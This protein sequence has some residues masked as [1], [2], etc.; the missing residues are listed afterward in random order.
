MAAGASFKKNSQCDRTSGI[1][2]RAVGRQRRA[3]ETR[4]AAACCSSGSKAIRVARNDGYLASLDRICG[5]RSACGGLGRA[6]ATVHSKTHE[7]HCQEMIMALRPCFTAARRV[8]MP[9]ATH[10][11]LAVLMGFFFQAEDGIRDGTVTGV[12]TCALPI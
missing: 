3:T 1:A 8:H 2:G 5:S 11:E 12:Q 4:G 6:V 9:L 10:S 7:R